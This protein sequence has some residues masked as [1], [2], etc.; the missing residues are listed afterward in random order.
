MYY[1]SIS[2]DEVEMLDDLNQRSSIMSLSNLLKGAVLSDYQTKAIAYLLVRKAQLVSADTGLGKTFIA[3]G[4][5]VALKNRYKD[6]KTVFFCL[7]D[8]LYQIKNDFDKHTNL[9]VVLTD[10]TAA[11]LS[12]AFELVK[13]ADVLLCTYECLINLEFNNNLFR[14]K[15]RF[16][17][18][19]MDE[20]HKVANLYSNT[21][22][23]L[24]SLTTQFE[25]KLELTA[26]P[27]TSSLKQGISAIC[28]LDKYIFVKDP[29]KTYFHFNEDLGREET[30]NVDDFK[31][32]INGLYFSITRAE[33]GLKGNYNV[34][35]DVVEPHEFQQ[36]P[37]ANI[38]MFV[39]MKGPGAFN[40][41]EKLKQRI[42]ERKGLKGLVY[43][44]KQEIYKFL[45][46]Q[47]FNTGIRYAIINGYTKQPERT[48]I[49]EAYHNGEY[50]VI[51]TD[52]ITSLNYKCDYIIFYELTCLF[53][54]AIGRGER[55][56]VKK[57]MDVIFI[58]TNHAK[59]LDYFFKNVY[60]RSEQ[61]KQAF[62]KDTSAIDKAAEQIYSKYYGGD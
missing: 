57:D 28:M 42:L 33:L 2:K 3:M 31:E 58:I 37:P 26:T 12:R 44:E 60:A 61:L 11:S 8:S 4:S 62:G 21:G 49:I 54:Q 20:I 30:R 13:T 46:E 25:Y 36:S 5:I 40:Q 10:A 51:F 34:I 7:K 14:M 53:Q 47:L 41:F 35:T 19:V 17:F 56:F 39:T 27:M 24:A 9:K 32:K 50:D 23:I 55:G 22:R 45:K 29:F 52:V 1:G 59:E 6:K 38:N 48:K 15:D 16:N 43:V 18:V